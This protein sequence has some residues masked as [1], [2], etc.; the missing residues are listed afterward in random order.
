[1]FPVFVQT[2]L[3]SVKNFHDIRK[4][5]LI[6]LIRGCIRPMPTPSSIVLTPALPNF[7]AV[8]LL[9]YGMHG[10]ISGS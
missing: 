5:L 3:D 4:G 7:L 9:I 8:Q 1:M 2:L 10:A 6:A